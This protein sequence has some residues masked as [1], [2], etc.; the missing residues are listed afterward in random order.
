MSFVTVKGGRLYLE[1]LTFVVN[2]C[3]K[4]LLSI[5]L[6]FEKQTDNFTVD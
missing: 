1:I 4:M 5:F 3:K 2:V 6:F